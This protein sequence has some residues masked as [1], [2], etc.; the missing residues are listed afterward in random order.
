MLY[1]DGTPF[2]TFTETY[3]DPS[4]WGVGR[5]TDILSRKNQII[6]KFR[7]NGTSWTQKFV[8][9]LGTPRVELGISTLRS[10]E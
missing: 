2:D 5:G 10:N 1:N 8:L 3:P 9:M 6:S 4:G 7:K